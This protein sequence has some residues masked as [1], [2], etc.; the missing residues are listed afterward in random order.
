[1]AIRLGNKDL[2]GGKFK[3]SKYQLILHLSLPDY[4]RSFRSPSFVARRRTPPRRQPRFLIGQF[5][6]RPLRDWSN[7]RDRWQWTR[8]GDRSWP[9][10]KR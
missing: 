1:M 9:D 7:R 2:R 4:L 6:L 5:R 10:W 8:P 3:I